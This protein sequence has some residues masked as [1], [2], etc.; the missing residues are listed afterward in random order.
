M[1]SAPLPALVKL[2][3]NVPKLGVLRVRSGCGVPRRPYKQVRRRGYTEHDTKSRVGRAGATGA[4]L[5]RPP[6]ARWSV[7][8]RV[9]AAPH[10]ALRCHSAL[11]RAADRAL[12]TAAYTRTQLARAVPESALS[13]SPGV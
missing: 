9:C 12:L 13:E 5:V 8:A 6:A 11:D 2:I 1:K 10:T 3:S 7:C 4:V